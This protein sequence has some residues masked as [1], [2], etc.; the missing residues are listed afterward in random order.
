MVFMAAAK[1]PDEAVT[2][3]EEETEKETVS[4]AVAPLD[5]EE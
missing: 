1:S 2:V 3:L 5:A 4:A